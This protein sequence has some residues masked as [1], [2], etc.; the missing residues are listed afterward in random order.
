[1]R[2][3]GVITGIGNPNPE[4]MDGQ[5]SGDPKRDKL[6]N[7]CAKDCYETFFKGT[8]MDY[9]SCDAGV[10]HEAVI[11]GIEPSYFGDNLRTICFYPAKDLCCINRG[12]AFGYY[13]SGIRKTTKSYYEYKTNSKFKRFIDKWHKELYA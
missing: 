12:H 5:S 1:M 8:K 3:S 2:Q 9:D 11:F 13:G 4:I 7:A 10:R 6:I